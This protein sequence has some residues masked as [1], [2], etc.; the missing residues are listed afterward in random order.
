MYNDIIK[1][2]NLEQFNLKIEDISTSKIG[3]DLFCY[4]TLQR[5]S[6]NCPICNSNLC[7]INDYRKKKIKHSIS[8][9]NP[10]YIIYNARRYKCKTCGY[11][12]YENNPFCSVNQKNST[13]NVFAVLNK[14]LS[15][16]VTFTEVAYNLKISV[17]TVMRIFDEYVDYS[18]YY[19]PKIMCWD[20]VYISRKTSYKYAFVMVDFMKRS[21]V[22]I[23]QSRHKNNVNYNLSRIP[24][25]QKDKVEYIIIDMWET[26]RDLAKYHFKNAKIAV[27]SFHV[28]QHLNKAMTNIRIKIMNKYNKKS[29]SLVNN[30]MY[31]YMIKKFHYFFTK[32]HD[33]IYNDLIPIRKMG[34][35]W[36]K[37]DIRKY[38]LDIDD[39]LK[40]AYLLKERYRE[41][42]LTA[43]YETCDE[44]FNELINE[45]T[46]SHLN[47]F[48]EFGKLLRHWKEY[49]KNSFVKVDGKRLS[50]G[51]ME[52]I[53]SRIKTIIK[54]ANGYSNFKRLR[55]R[56]AYSINKNVPIKG[57]KIKKNEK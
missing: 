57:T 8:T 22:D 45:F 42:N 20:E 5:E 47:E 29:N 44:E 37:D 53:N 2:L 50:N 38:L 28:I 26:Y 21:I 25:V 24:Q 14:L 48:R 10:C 35:K 3:M 27:D 23:Y 18:P 46:N 1:L 40:Y 41:F 7:N 17:T 19:L 36:L 30:D 43:E 56:I 15:H 4:I 51:P 54:S 16:T 6:I 13:Y 31:Y 55:N 32:K 33:D 34:T 9:S 12:F 52:G 49:I 11:V 39:D